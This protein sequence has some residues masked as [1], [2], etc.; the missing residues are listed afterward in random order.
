MNRAV[1]ITGFAMIVAGIVF[2]LAWFIKPLRFLWPWFRALPLLLQVGLGLAALGLLILMISLIWERISERH[3]DR[4][5][6][7][8]S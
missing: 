7:D 4:D 6:L 2:I 8:D 5:L 3:Q 1:R